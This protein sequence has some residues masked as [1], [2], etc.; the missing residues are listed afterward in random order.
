MS[1]SERRR[2]ERVV[3]VAS[4]TL[5]VGGREIVA[6]STENLSLQG[7]FVRSPEVVEPGT[8][9]RVYLE[10]S[11]RSSRLQLRMDGKI[12][13]VAP[14]RGLAVEF[15]SVGVDSSTYLK[16][17]VAHKRPDAGEENSKDF[18]FAD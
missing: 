4:A 14:G 5:V 6:Q 16:S 9:C 8:P 1:V 10:L 17:I 7:V 13:R 15:T 11:G 12:A 2:E 18:V 3:F